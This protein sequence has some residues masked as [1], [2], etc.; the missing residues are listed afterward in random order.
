MF[1]GLLEQARQKL[2]QGEDSDN[3]PSLIIKAI[4][5]DPNVATNM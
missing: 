1:D 5:D 3:L 2:E 4:D